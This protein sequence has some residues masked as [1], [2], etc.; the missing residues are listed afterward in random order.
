MVRT[1]KAELGSTTAK[2]GFSNEA[3]IAAKF[4]NW[5]SDA[6]AK[7]WLAA[8]NFPLAD[9][10]SVSAV[11]PN[12]EKSDVEITVVTGS[13]ISVKGISIKLVSGTTGFNQ[14]DKRWLSHYAK[15]WNMPQKT[16]DSLKLFLGEVPPSKPGKDAERMYLNEL[17]PNARKSIVD[18]FAANKDMI[19]SDL[20]MGDGKFRADWILV[21][22]KNTE[23]PHWAIRNVADAM[24]YFS[25]GDVAVTTRGNLRI[26]RITM[27]RKGGDAGRD[28]A[29]MLQFK[30]NP[31][32]LFDMK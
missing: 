5:R 22:Q 14:V 31:A 4:E 8:M 27:Q 26:G 17:D 25:E 7:I 21:A 19:V 1:A 23:T 16:Y 9:I 20:F 29:K 13:G 6:D 32:L 30:I 28:T 12:G 11:R 24:K 18:F 15:M 3:E 10:K 2:N